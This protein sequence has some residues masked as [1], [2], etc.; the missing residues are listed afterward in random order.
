MSPMTWLTI[1]PIVQPVA[2][3]QPTKDGVVAYQP[4]AK[5]RVE[6]V[7]KSNA[8]SS[9]KITDADKRR[10]FQTIVK[11]TKNG[12]VDVNKFENELNKIFGGD[13]IRG[14][15]LQP[16]H[17]TPRKKESHKQLA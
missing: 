15:T 14:L 12:N 16:W 5:D 17:I 7:P 3:F 2:A 9:P 11:H 4:V 1:S 10:A 13:I 6:Q 8:K